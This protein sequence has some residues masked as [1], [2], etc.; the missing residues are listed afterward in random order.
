[1]S[2]KTK[3]PQA[4]RGR[5]SSSPAADAP[6]AGARR[7]HIVSIDRTK[8]TE[9]RYYR[10]PVD[11]PIWFSTAQDL[12]SAQLDNISRGGLRLST[13]LPLMVGHRIL[14]DVPLFRSDDEWM[15]LAEGEVVWS[16][17]S[18]FGVHFFDLTPSFSTALQRFMR[19]Y[20]LAA[21]ADDLRRYIDG[22]FSED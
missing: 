17:G 7:L 14:L 22:L 21:S 15:S 13:A 4:P 3:G 12:Y 18:Q 19:R 10:F 6:S 1:M 5:K 2:K 16:A 9:R 11:K 8:R 20:L